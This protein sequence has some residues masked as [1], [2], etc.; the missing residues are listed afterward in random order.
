MKD[1]TVLKCLFLLCLML[2]PA[3]AGA[4]VPPV[5]KGAEL[6]TFV[7]GV[8][9]AQMMALDVA[10]ASVAIVRDGQVIYTGGRGIADYATGRPVVP[11]ETLFRLGSTSKL[12]TW[13]A[14]MQVYERGLVDL[15]ADINTYL[16]DFQIPAAFGAPITLR[17]LMTHTSGF[18]DGA[19]GFLIR[20]RPDDLLPLAESLK[21]YMPRR[22]NPPGA[23]STYSNYATALAGYIVATV[24]GM[25]FEAYV[26]Q[27]I[28][29]PLG[30]AS[31]T[32]REPLPAALEPRRAI[33]Y[34]RENG[35]YAAQPFQYISGL[36]PAGS[37]SSTA[38]DMARFMMALLN[39]GELDGAR[40]LKP[41]TARLMQTPGYFADRRLPGLG[42]GL[43][44]TR[45]NGHLL[46]GHGGDT[47]LFHT[48]LM[49]DR[50]HNLGIF[51]TT[52]GAEGGTLR[53]QLVSLF[54]D[55]YFP[56]DDPAILIPDPDAKTAHLQKYAG[57]YKMWRTSFSTIE[58]ATMILN[59]IQIGVTEQGT[60]S[61]SGLGRSE[62]YMEVGENLF[63]QIDGEEMISFKVDDAGEVVALNAGVAAFMQARPSAFYETGSFNLMLFLLSSLL[64]GLGLLRAFFRRDI[65]REEG[66]AARWARRLTVVAGAAHFLFLATMGSVLAAY[67]INVYFGVPLAFKLTLVFPMLFVAASIGVLVLL[68]RSWVADRAGVCVRAG[69]VGA[70]A[71][72][73]FLCWFYWFWN[74]LGVRI[75]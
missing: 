48:N 2:L 14:V 74:I 31:T 47:P 52:N 63:R 5:E 69:Q 67:G 40:I 73:A 44:F 50:A 39:F 57:E 30:M 37:G 8:L 3:G 68:V 23:V 32:S 27:H 35:A 10:A 36:A 12:F 6:D 15:D 45:Q 61:F 20:N 17:H 55:H 60:L 4:Q 9:D 1:Q 66:Q 11:E 53:S 56:S 16:K 26:E 41:E 58:K 62:Q 19:L 49:L 71:A 21:R 28:Y 7:D 75:A 59:G 13:V 38:T 18:E 22:I 46:F 51:V 29:G 24:S 42:L 34:L 33:G 54:Y 64:L 65:V 70:L 72:L 25:P 43:Y